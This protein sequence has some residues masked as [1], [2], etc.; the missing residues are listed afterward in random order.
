LLLVF[1]VKIG[2]FGRVKGE[3]KQESWLSG[4]LGTKAGHFGV[5]VEVGL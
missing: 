1:Q 5:L 3:C 2:E 4:P